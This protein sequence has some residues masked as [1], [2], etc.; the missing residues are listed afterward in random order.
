MAIKKGGLGKG[1][2]ALFPEAATPQETKPLHLAIS[3]ITPDKNQP[4]K[5]FSAESL[6]EL[7]ASIAQHGVLQ[8]ITVRPNPIGGYQLIAGERRWRASRQAGLVEIPAIVKDLSDAQA[9][10]I[11]LIENLQRED[12][13]PVEEAFGYR[14]LIESCNLT[15]E[16][17]AKK[18]SKSR[19]SVTNSLRLLNLHK[20]VLDMLSAK[21]IT[22]GHAKALLSLENQDL[23][24]QAAAQIVEENLNVRQAETLCKK[25]VAPAPKAYEPM[26][27]PTLPTEVAA[28]LKEVL[29]TEVKVVYKDGKGTINLS[30]YSD[31][32]LRELANLLDKNK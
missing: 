1:L 28:S 13:D 20:N 9:M 18:V 19:P 4:R 17:A 14:Q 29:G 16:E 23:Q 12:L 7:A 30:F 10:E 11:A 15:Q 26:G 22:A 27:A 32:Q 5:N 31:E 24:Q 21:K 6:N 2:D 3:E 25:I 8:P